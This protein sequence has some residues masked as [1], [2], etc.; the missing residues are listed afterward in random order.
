MARIKELF[1]MYKDVTADKLFDNL[2]YFLKAIQPVCEKY[3]IKMAIH[4]DDP[5]WPVFGLARIITGKEQ[6]LK[7][8][9]AVDAPFNGVTLCTGS[10]EAIRTMIFRISFALSKEEFILPM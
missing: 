8:M 2:V 7:L 6:L 10:L 3:D 5:A 4:P 1:A 9:R